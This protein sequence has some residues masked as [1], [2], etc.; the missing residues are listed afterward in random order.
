MVKSVQ[1]SIKGLSLLLVA[2]LFIGCGQQQTETKTKKV[3]MGPNVTKAVA[4]I[5]PVNGEEVSGVVHFTKTENGVQIEANL[6]NLSQGKHGFHI[7]QYG[8]CSNRKD[9]TS[10]G[11]HYNPMQQSHGSPTADQRHVGDMGNVPAG[12][13]GNGE[14]TYTDNTIR[15]NGKHSVVGR[16][17]ILHAGE[18][19]L[20]SQ[21]S[22]AAGSRVGCGVIGIAETQPDTS[23]ASM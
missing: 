9:F 3:D 19:D 21:P 2:I 7:H 5:Q 16:A 1:H 14:L 11:G 15:L 22:G 6:S 8:N 10:A 13:E 18:D 12:P 4:T 23:S 17:I 20:E